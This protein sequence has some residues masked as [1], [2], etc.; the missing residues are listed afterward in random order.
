MS[1]A[2][3]PVFGGEYRRLYGET[4]LA[5]I[6]SDHENP[7]NHPIYVIE[8]DLVFSIVRTTTDQTW[9]LP[10]RNPLDIKQEKV[11]L[12]LENKT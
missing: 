2:T 12:E 8:K 5:H 3:V 10:V 11:K 7:T 9:C 4:Q 1:D 6:V